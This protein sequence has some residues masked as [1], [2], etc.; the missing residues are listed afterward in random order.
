MKQRI[1]LLL[2]AGVVF[3]VCSRNVFADQPGFATSRW[4]VDVKGGTYWTKG[5]KD[6]MTTGDSWSPDKNAYGYA[7]LFSLSSYSMACRTLK[8]WST[9]LE[10]GIIKRSDL[11]FMPISLFKYYQFASDGNVFIPRIGFGLTYFHPLEKPKGSSGQTMTIDMSKEFDAL[12]DIGALIKVHEDTYISFDVREGMFAALF[13]KQYE[14]TITGG[15][16]YAL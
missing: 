13:S 16:V 2:L 14:T 3:C 1:I 7:A 12:I 11:S 5:G 8:G 6:S 10:V 15:V 4:T 9:A